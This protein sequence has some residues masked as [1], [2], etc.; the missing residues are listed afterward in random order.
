MN[1]NM[2]KVLVSRSELEAYCAAQDQAFGYDAMRDWLYQYAETAQ[3]SREAW[4][5]YHMMM[6]AY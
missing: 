3:L 4:S 5:F 2:E 6:T 1:K